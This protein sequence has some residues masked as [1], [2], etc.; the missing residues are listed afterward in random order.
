[1]L[2]SM[3]YE[4][5]NGTGLEGRVTKKDILSYIENRKTDTSASTKTVG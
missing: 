1:M 5:F 3:N 2:V 4:K